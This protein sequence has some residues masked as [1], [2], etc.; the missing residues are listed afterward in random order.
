MAGS[1]L[2]T[3]LLE[4]REITRR[5]EDGKTVKEILTVEQQAA[6]LGVGWKPC[7]EIDDTIVSSA[8]GD[9]VIVPIAYDAGDHIA[10][11]YEHRYDKQKVNAEIQTLKDELNDSDYKVTKCYEASLLGRELPYDIA[12]LYEQRQSKRDRINELEAKLR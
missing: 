12:Y 10:Y 9:D 4:Q 2:H 1:Y 8:T 11:R 3:R 7:D 5:G 6:E